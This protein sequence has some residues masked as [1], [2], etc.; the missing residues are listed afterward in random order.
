VK[1]GPQNMPN[2]SFG[3]NQKEQ[4][5]SKYLNV[6][7]E[8]VAERVVISSKENSKRSEMMREIIEERMS[9]SSKSSG[10]VFIRGTFNKQNLT[11]LGQR[12]DFM[13]KSES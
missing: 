3:Q 6:R 11:N 4:F 1:A 12:R 13:Y 10:R 2:F 5:M 9:K 8:G 7:Q